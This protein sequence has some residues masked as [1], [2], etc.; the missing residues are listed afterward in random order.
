[1]SDYMFMLESHLSTD[2]NRVVTEV[3]SAAAQNNV[4]LFLTGGAM[5][6]MLGSFPIRDLDFTVES[7]NAVKLA[8]FV[9]KQAGAQ[10]LSED[11]HRKLAELSFPGGVTAS[12]GMARREIYPKP[13]ARSQVVPATIHEDLGSRDFTVNA[14]ALSL[15]RASRGLLLDPTNGLG[16]LERKELRTVYNYALYDDPARLLRLIQFKVRLGFIVQERTQSQYENVRAEQLEKKIPARRLFEELQ[17]MADEPKAGEILENLAKESLLGLFSPALTGP[18]LNLAGLARLQKAHQ[19]IPAGVRLPVEGL[20]LFL[21]VLTEKLTPKEKAALVQ[22][23]A[24]KKDEVDLWQKLDARAKK[25]EKELSGPRLSR[26]A[27]VYQ[28]LSKAPGDHI[29]HLLLRSS[30]RLVQDRIR[31]YLQKYLPMAQEITDE[32]VRGKGVEP[33]TPKFQ[34]VRE[35]LIAAHLNARPKKPVEE[36]EPVKPPEPAF[37]PGRRPLRQP[38]VRG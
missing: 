5:R 36:P 22:A 20:G 26:P 27:Q 11:E 24:M 38:I 37:P 7:A 13:G 35:E 32:D 34:K 30:S 12:I 9:A 21:S 19:L 3:Q 17:S 28:V 25:L 8:R 14:I 4:S 10:V 18:K 31:N 16:D 2:Q 1:M 15:N 6:D 33:G 23:T 29:L